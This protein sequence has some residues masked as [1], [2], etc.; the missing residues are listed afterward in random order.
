MNAAKVLPLIMLLILSS[1][2][3]DELRKAELTGNYRVK[4]PGFRKNFKLS[5][6]RS[7]YTDLKINTR[8]HPLYP[9]FNVH[10]EI[11]GSSLKIPRQVINGL[12]EIEGAGTYSRRSEEIS[13]DYTLNRKDEFSL[14]GRRIQD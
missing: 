3:D 6:K 4:Y 9:D 13:F 12:I 1:S 2:C 10:V 8:W 5:V 11:D 14:F 7:S